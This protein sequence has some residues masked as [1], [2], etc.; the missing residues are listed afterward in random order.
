MIKAY[1]LIFIDPEI[2]FGKPYI[3]RTRIA[4]ADILQWLARLSHKEII[5]DYT[6]LQEEHI[7]AA[8]TFKP[9]LTNF[10]LNPKQYNPKLFY[11]L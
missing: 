4:D 5:D 8:L 2:R 9:F 3:K 1:S 6:T 10:N 7:L 11:Y